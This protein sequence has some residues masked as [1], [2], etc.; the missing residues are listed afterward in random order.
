MLLGNF[1]NSLVDMEF[2]ISS[3]ILLAYFSLGLELLFAHVPS[4]ASNKAI[5]KA[6]PKVVNAYPSAYQ[7]IFKLPKL[8]KVFLFLLPLGLLYGVFLMPLMI[9][10]GWAPWLALNTAISIYLQIIGIVLIVLGRIITLVSVRNMIRN[11]DKSGEQ[12]LVKKQGAFGY[13]RNPIQVGMYMFL[14]GVSLSLVSFWLFLGVIYYVG[15]MHFKIK[16][17]EQYLSKQYGE[18]YLEYMRYTRRYL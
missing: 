11:R 6:S 10:L 3:I 17:E 18:K 16:M 7:W 8:S 9:I 13:S 14:I 12:G 15:Y 1:M 5:W 2:L 4:I